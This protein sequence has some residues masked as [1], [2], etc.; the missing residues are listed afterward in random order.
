MSS[1]AQDGVWMICSA[2]RFLRS[3]VIFFSS[4]LAHYKLPDLQMEA[5]TVDHTQSLDIQAWEL[6]GRC[7]FI[8]YISSSDSRSCHKKKKR[9][10][11]YCIIGLVK[12]HYSFYSNRTEEERDAV[13]GTTIYSWMYKWIKTMDNSI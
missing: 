4:R 5:D 8:F 7:R 13:E 1:T 9:K 2:C 12:I 3:E 6:V 10:K 11:N